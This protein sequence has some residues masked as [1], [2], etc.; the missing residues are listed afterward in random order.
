MLVTI[1]FSAMDD[2]YITINYIWPHMGL[3]KKKT[4]TE[5]IKHLYLSRKNFD[6][7]YKT[8][9]IQAYSTNNLTYFQFW[10]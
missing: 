7:P 6:I 5:E 4:C 10:N 2:Y 3:R 1:I 9:K 8:S